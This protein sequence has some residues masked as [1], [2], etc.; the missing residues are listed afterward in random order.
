MA[1]INHDMLSSVDMIHNILDLV[2]IIAMVKLGSRIWR[3]SL[4]LGS[5]TADSGTLR[6][7]YIC[8]VSQHAFITLAAIMIRIR[9]A[10]I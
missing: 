4:L 5:Y 3:A 2:S 6:Q 10:R 9:F 1:F 8:K 7:S